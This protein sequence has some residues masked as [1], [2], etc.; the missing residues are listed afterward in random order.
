MKLTKK[1]YYILGV[2][3]VLVFLIVVLFLSGYFQQQSVECESDSDCALGLRLD[4][5]CPCPEAFA[6]SEINADPNIVIY[7][8]GKDYSDLIKVDCK[9]VQCAPCPPIHQIK[10][11]CRN[12]RCVTYR[13][14]QNIVINKKLR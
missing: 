13:F 14:T 5:C 7:E 6:I 1:H 8:E 9:N 11:V 4:K 10:A 2:F 3:C 12:K